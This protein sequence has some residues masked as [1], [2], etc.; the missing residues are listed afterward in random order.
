MHKMILRSILGMLLGAAISPTTASTPTEDDI[1]VRG[2]TISTHSSGQDW[3]DEVM[4][5]T[6][7]EIKT[8]GANW[9]AT[10]PY[11]SIAGDG[12]VGRRRR[13]AGDDP[14]THWTRP[15]VEAHAQG[16][17]VCIKPHLAYWRSGFSWRG[18]IAFDTDEAWERFWNDY[19]AWIL[20]LA[21]ACSK[22]DAFIIGTEL[23][24]TLHH[25]AKW[26]TLIADVR[27]VYG[28]PITY[29]ANW[30]DY[31]RVPFW[32]ALDMIGIQGY[33]PVSEGESPTA[34]DI[35]AGWQR[36]VAEL[37]AYGEKHDRNILFTELGYN[38]SYTTAAKPW[39]Y[40]SDDEGARAIQE[41]CWLTALD[42]IDNEPR[43]L[44]SLLWKWF[45]HPHP[46]GRNFQLATPPIM[47]IIADAWQGDTQITI[48]EP[49]PGVDRGVDDRK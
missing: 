19:S 38:Q 37:R 48:H 17:K 45:P 10:H 24:R 1:V 28:G 41:L 12:S 31:R 40:R 2:I 49:P 18:E 44:G 30:S 46:I 8:L 3:G 5:P 47:R 22:A 15:I 7:R 11:G 27:K 16:L 23:D 20:E 32:D 34:V 33:F 39:D 43:I 6:I 35:R 21:A 29:A 14:P 25:E 9:I 13:G 26:R 36:I 4:V 42:A